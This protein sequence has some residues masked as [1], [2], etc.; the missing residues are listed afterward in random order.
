MIIFFLKKKK[1]CTYGEDPA[2]LVNPATFCLCGVLQ[3]QGYAVKAQLL[4]TAGGLKLHND[5]PWNASV[6][7][8]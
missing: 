2:R 5:V 8:V 3:H 4:E 7:Q 1:N 6:A